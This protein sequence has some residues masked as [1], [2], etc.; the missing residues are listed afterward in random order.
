KRREIAK[1]VATEAKATWVP[2]QTMF[3]DAVAA[4]TSAEALARDGVHPSQDGHALM[5]KTWRKIV[6]I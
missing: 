1:A 2:F 3:D 5:A 4:G 6:G